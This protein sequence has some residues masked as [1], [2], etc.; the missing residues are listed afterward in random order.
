MVLRVYS[1]LSLLS[2]IILGDVFLKDHVFLIMK[3]MCS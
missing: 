1:W 3:A 2:G